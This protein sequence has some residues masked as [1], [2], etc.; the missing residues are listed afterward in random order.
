V[1]SWHWGLL[2]GFCQVGHNLP[3]SLHVAYFEI[4]F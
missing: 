2:V 3:G 4:V 1:S